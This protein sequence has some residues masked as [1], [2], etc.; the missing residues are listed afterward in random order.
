MYTPNFGLVTER[1]RTQKGK[2][3]DLF[4]E[5]YDDRPVKERTCLSCSATEEQEAKLHGMGIDSG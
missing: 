1:I 5:C 2:F 4:I 3:Y